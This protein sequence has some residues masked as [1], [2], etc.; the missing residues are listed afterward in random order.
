MCL[1]ANAPNACA[2]VCRK[3]LMNVAV[4]L[5]ADPNLKFQEY[6]DWLHTNHHVPPNSKAWVDHIRLLGNSAN[7]EIKLVTREEAKDALGFTEMVLKIVYEFPSRLQS[8][9]S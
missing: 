5:G 4:H 1:K 7:H 8:K 9:K 3:I 2:M 6:V